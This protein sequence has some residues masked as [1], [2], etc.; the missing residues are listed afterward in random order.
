VEVESSEQMLEAVMSRVAEI[1]IFIGAAAV[2]DYR[3]RAVA[4]Q[5]IKKLAEDRMSLQLERTPDIL[6]Q[7]AAL[8]RKPFTVGFAAETENV[9]D[10]ARSKLERKGLDMIAANQV[11][12]SDRGF[13]AES[14]ALSVYWAG[15]ERELAM[16]PKLVLARR[17]IALIAERYH[18][19]RTA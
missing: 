1:D 8:D 4:Q 11:G 9:A 5:K 6:A 19:A 3:P 2:A 12:V 7:V 13:N 17:L 16:A 14:N 10:N 18:A 15:G